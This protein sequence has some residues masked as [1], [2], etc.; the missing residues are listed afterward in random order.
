[1]SVKNAPPAESPS[2][3]SG[4]GPWDSGGELR[5]GVGLLG[6]IFELHLSS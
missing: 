1:M 2:F 6:L 3:P 5:G 4:S